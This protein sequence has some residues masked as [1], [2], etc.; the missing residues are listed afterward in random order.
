MAHI[1]DPSEQAWKGYMYAGILFGTSLLQTV[2]SI[3]YQKRILLVGMRIRTVLSGAVYRK[4]LVVGNASKKGKIIIKLFVFSFIYTSFT[5]LNADTT[6]GE[7]VNLMAVD[8]QR[9]M[10]LCTFVHMGWTSLI[11]IALSLYFLHNTLGP[12]VFTGLAIMLLLIPLNGYIATKTRGFQMQQM[13]LKDNRVKLMSELMAGMK[14]LKL[15]GWEN[16]FQVFTGII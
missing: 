16:S 10:D 8:S 14:V 4:A 12:S 3:Q 2:F 6:V 7:I 1:V 9:I 13:I 15:Y 11:Q 5:C